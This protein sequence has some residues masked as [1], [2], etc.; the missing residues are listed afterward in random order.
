[1]RLSAGSRRTGFTLVEL[2]V[3]IAII[4]ILVALLLPAV[5]AAR[6]ASRRSN[7]SNNLKNLALAIQNHHDV[8]K[9]LP[10]GAANDKAPDFGKT[11]AGASWGSSF[12][13]YLLPFIEQEA[14]QQKLILGGTATMTDPNYDPIRTY[15]S[16]GSG[17]DLQAK[18]NGTA[19]TNYNQKQIDGVVI[20]VMRCP[21]SPLPITNLNLNG[22]GAERGFCPSYVGIAGA[23]CYDAATTI[24]PGFV[25]AGRNTNGGHGWYAANGSLCANA[26]FTYSQLLDGTANVMILSEHGDFMVDQA[27]GRQRFRASEPYGWLMGAGNSNSEIGYYERIFNCTVVRYKVNNKNNSGAGWNT[28]NK[29]TTGVGSDQGLNTPLNSAHP[30]GVMAARADGSVQFLP[31][32]TD[33][34]LLGRL[35]VRDDGQTIAE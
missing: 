11:P 13:A 31:T 1:M 26:R 7:C 22:V 24:I 29:A 3:V 17:H 21:S 8:Y 2:L 5:Q 25:D 18:I 27:G 14:L 30:G 33:L 9:R 16:G 6:E 34:A 10:P 19:V 15:I 28:A 4:G 35:A 12:Y 23:V 32:T 20:S